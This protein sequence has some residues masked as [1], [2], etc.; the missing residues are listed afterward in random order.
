MQ[1]DEYVVIA[2]REAIHLSRA[3]SARGM[4]KHCSIEIFRNEEPAAHNP[5]FAS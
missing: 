4:E 5:T 2:T 3:Y 1:D